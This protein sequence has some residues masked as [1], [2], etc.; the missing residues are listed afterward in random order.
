LAE[1]VTLRAEI[2]QQVDLQWKATVILLTTTGAVFGFALSSIDRIPLLLIVPYSSYIL[3][4]RWIHSQA[5]VDRAAY[6]IRTE[7]ASK[8]PGGLGFEHWIK[9]RT[10]HTGF[11]RQLLRIAWTRPTALTYPGLSGLALGTVAVWF[12]A[13]TKPWAKV[14]IISGVIGWSLGL[15]L[16]FLSIRIMWSAQRR[17]ANSEFFD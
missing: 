6:Y 14:A 2:L 9:T 11:F 7:L 10:A 5:L 17:R 8:V 1:Y 13:S 12:G 3:C 16:T 4:T 15:L